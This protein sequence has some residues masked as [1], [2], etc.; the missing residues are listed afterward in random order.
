MADDDPHSM[1]QKQELRP[2]NPGE[3]MKLAKTILR[4]RDFSRENYVERAKKF[5]EARDE[6]KRL[7]RGAPEKRDRMI[8]A[9][10]LVKM[11]RTRCK[12]AKRIRVLGTKRVPPIQHSGKRIPVVVAVR[13]SRSAITA[14]Q[15]VK[16]ALR[17]LRLR[18]PETLVFLRNAKETAVTLNIVR[19]FVFWGCPSFKKVFNL[20]HKRGHFRTK[21]TEKQ[22]KG[23]R[24]PLSDNAIV[25]E[26]FSDADI[27]CTEDVAHCVYNATDHFDSVTKRLCPIQLGDPQTADSLIKDKKIP[28]GN[29]EGAINLHI[30]KLLG[31]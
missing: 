11:A 10:K 26:H 22:P 24:V 17:E 29:V 1:I 23:G 2:R 4:R 5:K 15:Q 14:H 25:E 6:R 16:S 9:A 8:S 19:P 27:L 3:S 21:P 18:K 28:F 7:K 13:N 20:L 12:D 30:K 31:E